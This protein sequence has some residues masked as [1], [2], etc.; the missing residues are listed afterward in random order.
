MFTPPLTNG[1]ITTT[2]RIGTD[3]SDIITSQT[4]YDMAGQMAW[5]TDALGHQT[6]FTN[7]TDASG[8]SV[9]LVNRQGTTSTQTSARDHS[10]LSK[11]GNAAPQVRYD[12]GAAQNG[13]VAHRF[14]KTI[15]LDGNDNDTAEWTQTFQ[16]AAGRT[17][18]TVYVDGA[19]ATSLYN[20]LGQLSTQIDPDGVTTLYQY[21]PAGQLEY[22]AIDANRNGAIDMTGPD[23]V[24][25]TVSDVAVH[26]TNV[27][28]RTQTFVYADGT[29]NP[30][31]VSSTETAVDAQRSWSYSGRGTN[32]TDTSFTGA[33]AWTSTQ[34]VADGTI[35]T[36]SYQAN[37][38]VGLVVSDPSITLRQEAREYDTH[39]RLW[40]VTDARNGTTTYG[41]NDADQITSVT[42][43]TPGTGQSAQITTTV[44]DDFGRPGLVQAADS[45]WLTNTY[46]A[47]GLIQM[48]LGGKDYPAAYTYDYAGRKQTMTT[49]GA[50]G[51][52]ITT[53]KYNS[54]G[55]L[56]SK[57]YPDG[58]G[59][60]FTYTPAG[61][62]LTR[63]WAR[64]VV[65]TSAYDTAGRL[66]QTS[67]SD[68]TPS[69]N[70]GYNRMGRV[71]S[72]NG[73][74][75]GTLQY[76]A[77]G[78]LLA[79]D[80][81]DANLGYGSQLRS[82][83]DGLNRVQAVNN[84]TI[85]Y[86]STLGYT[87][88]R[89]IN[90]SGG[91]RQAIYGYIPN[92]TLLASTT[93]Q[94]GSTSLATTRQYDALNRLQSISTPGFSAAYNYNSANQ[95]TALTNADGSFWQYG[96]D[97]LGQVTSGY[98][99]W[100]GGELVAGQQFEF[101]YDAIGNRTYDK[102]GGNPDGTG[103]RQANYSV[104]SLNQYTSREVP[105]FIEA[106][107]SVA[108]TASVTVNGLAPTQQGTYFR[109]ELSVD[110]SAAGV[111]TN[112]AIVASDATSTNATSRTTFVP[113]TPETFRYDLDGNRTNDAQWNYT[114][115]AENRLVHMAAVAAVPAD[116]QIQ[117]DYTYDW[118]GR[119]IAKTV[120]QN[121]Q[122]TSRWKFFYDGWNLIG[123]QDDVTGLKISY[124]WGLDLSRTRRG[125]GGVGGLLWMIVHTGSLAGTYSYV[126]DG[127]GNVIGLINMADGS[128]AAHYQYGP[129]GE[130]LR[131]TGPLA[132]MNHFCF[133]TK[134]RDSETGLY[135]YGY[136]Y[137]EPSTGKWLSSDPI[138]E[139]GG[140]NLN[141]LNGNNPINTFD[142]LGCQIIVNSTTNLHESILVATNGQFVRG[143]T[144]TRLDV[145][146]TKTKCYLH[147]AGEFTLRLRLLDSS[148]PQWDIRLPRYDR[149]NAG[150]NRSNEVE[151]EATLA[152]ESDHVRTYERFIDV[153]EQLNK[154]EGRF[155]LTDW[156][157]GILEQNLKTIYG[158][159]LTHS[160]RFD[161][162][163]EDWNSGNRYMDH[164][165]VPTTSL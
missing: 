126:H 136:R 12:Y 25:R 55:Q 89:M 34:T 160:Q 66:Q 9:Q 24:T 84:W 94:Q 95:R 148:N 42:T 150:G 43:P 41:Y 161:Q 18:K 120:T 108:S 22:T 79:E 2:H 132:T 113:A 104:N 116:L 33:G 68:G 32:E 82:T 130:L 98:K 145:S 102:R 44:Y 129:F 64:G 10:L 111:F 100:P 39:N 118:Q 90:V 158:E 163:D 69:I 15:Q 99:Y 101:S 144:G 30:T 117:L 27:V 154:L 151:R 93:V 162:D 56:Q 114:W 125:A 157:A 59:P 40:K 4:G 7:Y 92:S 146:V 16:D 103:M 134:Y 123:E 91:A 143:Q 127:N 110:N 142:A 106:S 112:V 51:A 149:W 8:Q 20:G 80:I 61:R 73:A 29:G 77:L 62:V 81:S 97:T 26:G 74:V 83:L 53:W 141:S 88:S 45:T 76:S 133:A 75:S 78:Q 37:R 21:N 6:T 38:A 71:S 70:L 36:T 140:L 17:T 164:P 138:A 49:W 14:V 50:S 153:I 47:N 156:E 72:I 115:N 96:Y 31:L 119:R 159:A 128:I 48:K 3:G 85:Q 109:R 52:A 13:G 121:G 65:T 35:T 155:V 23:Q 107:G 46:F 135:Y 165:F 152:H 63:T 57:V 122:T 87:G 60:T 58:N 139:T 28:R 86:A 131:A 1:N 19:E 105:G 5:S 147:I 54:R 11:K 67:Y 124:T 137:Y